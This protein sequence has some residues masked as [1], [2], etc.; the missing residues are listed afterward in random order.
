MIMAAHPNR[1]QEPLGKFMLALKAASDPLYLR[2]LNPY[3][4][5][6]RELRLPASA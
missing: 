4:D 1:L 5:A 6:E 2:F 3:G